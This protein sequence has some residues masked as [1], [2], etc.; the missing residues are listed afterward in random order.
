MTNKIIDRFIDLWDYIRYLPY[1]IYIDMKY[2]STNLRRIIDFV[3]IVWSDYDFD[4]QSGLY[5][6]IYKKL[7]RLEPCLRNGHLLNGEKYA[8]EVRNVMLVLERI[9][10]DDY[11]FEERLDHLKKW[12][13]YRIG[14]ANSDE[15][16][17]CNLFVTTEE[18][19]KLC[20]SEYFDIITKQ[21]HLLQRDI[22]WV[23]RIIGERHLYWW[24]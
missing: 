23:F 19:E 22:D 16:T 5:M 9:M 8:K 1:R 15:K 10:A 20:K 12:G 13:Q 4:C 24:D 2:W 21:G 3:P 18:E 6:L 17:F 11:C 14:R 7:E